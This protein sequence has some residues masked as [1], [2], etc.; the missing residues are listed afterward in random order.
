MS[1][2]SYVDVWRTVAEAQPEAV[3]LESGDVVVTWESFVHHMDSLGSYFHS[4]DLPRQSTVAAYLYNCP[5]YLITFAGTLA[6]G[7]VPINTNYRYGHDELAYL[8]DNADTRVLV[9]HGAFTDKIDAL[10]GELPDIVAYLHVDDGTTPCPPWATPFREALATPPTTLPP[11]SPDDLV[12]LY[13]GGTTG[14]PKGVMWRQDDLFV[15][16]NSGGFRKY[17]EEG[18][19]EDVRRCIDEAGAGYTLLPACPLMHGTGLFT[20]IRALGEAG[21]VVLLPSRHFDPVEL[22]TT[23]QDFDVNVAVIVGDPFAR[24][25]LHEL[26]ANPARYPLASLVSI[27]SSGAMWSQEI[28]DG[29]IDHVPHVLLVDTFG[30]TE[31][32]G[33]GS[34]L[35][36]KKRT[37]ATATFSLGPL[38]RVVDDNGDDVTPGSDTIGKVMI[39]GRNPLGYYKDA[40]KSAATFHTIE[41]VR[42]SVPGDFATVLADGKIQLLGRGSQCINTAGEKVFPEEVEEALKTHPSVADACVVG[43]PH[44]LYGQQVVGAVELYPGHDADVDELIQHVKSRLAHYKAPRHLRVVPTIGRAVNGKMDYAR[45]QREAREW[46][47]VPQS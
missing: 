34:S 13:T 24:P 42:Y 6:A 16:L 30:S 22:A 12:M 33:L 45:H 35:S 38:V 26:R 40:A 2:W 7:H 25:L 44:E 43:V 19:L 5:E 28:K 1:S 18:G 27:V 3:A 46:L 17:P 41:G 32:L 10:R 4:L 15:R 37:S 36:S 39:G 31:A 47:G 14:M 21:R 20:A 29:L 8:F 9:F 11:S 23:L